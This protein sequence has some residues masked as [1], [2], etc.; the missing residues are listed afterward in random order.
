[1]EASTI[2]L[3]GHGCLEDGLVNVGVELLALG[4]GVEALET[5]LLE[6]GDQD[7]V[8]HLEAIVKCDEVL[9]LSDELSRLDGGERAVEVVNG[10]D[11]VAGEALE[12]KVFGGLNLTLCALLE[13]AIVCDRSE[14]LVLGRRFLCPSSPA[15]P[16][17]VLQRWAAP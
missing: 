14:V 10:L 8:G 11:E 12:R 4:R 7:V 13:V 15:A 6:G 9:V 16:S 2:L 5:V 3:V 1:M 17:A